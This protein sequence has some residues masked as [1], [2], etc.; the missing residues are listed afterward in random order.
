MP[1]EMVT[2]TARELSLTVKA[3]FNPKELSVEK[4]VSWTPKKPA[5][6]DDPPA[7]FQG[8]TPATLSATLYFDTYESGGDVYTDHVRKLELMAMMIT[9]MKR[10][11]HC[12]FQ[13]GKFVFAGVI[14]S[15]GQKYT[16]FMSDGRR[17]RCECTLKMTAAKSAEA[18]KSSATSGG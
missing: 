4:T 10:P 3:M 13:W 12:V 8:P 15:L 14:S 18:G 1:S 2:I 16:M 17:V 5:D 7:E 11:P 9:D 6:T